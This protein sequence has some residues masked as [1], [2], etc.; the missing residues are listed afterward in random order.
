MVGFSFE[1]SVSSRPPVV[2]S[3]ASITCG[4]TRAQQLHQ[5]E[6]RRCAVS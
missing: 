1:P 5:L 2:F 4:A 3:A 6:R